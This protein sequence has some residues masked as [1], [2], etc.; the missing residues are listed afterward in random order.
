MSECTN[1][2]NVPMRKWDSSSH[3]RKGNV[4]SMYNSHLKPI[5]QHMACS[6]YSNARVQS[7][8]LGQNIRNDVCQF[9]HLLLRQLLRRVKAMWVDIGTWWQF[10][11]DDL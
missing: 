1:G 9:V 8:N 4:V 7:T 5:T 3:N 2:I 10:A 6:L 11:G